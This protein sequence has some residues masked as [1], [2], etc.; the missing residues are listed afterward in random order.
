GI[1]S[2]IAPPVSASQSC[3]ADPCD[4]ICAHSPDVIASSDMIAPSGSNAANALPKLSV[5]NLPAPGNSGAAPPVAGPPTL[6][7]TSSASAVRTSTTSFSLS[8]GWYVLHSGDR[9]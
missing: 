8:H 7:P 4:A 2:P 5:V 6:A 9:K 1:P 3:G